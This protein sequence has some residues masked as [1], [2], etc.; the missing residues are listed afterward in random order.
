MA[1]DYAAAHPKPSW[2]ANANKDNFVDL[3]LYHIKHH[4]EALAP[5]AAR[6]ATPPAQ[7]EHGA[8]LL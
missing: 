5:P 6:V 7:S 3:L 2:L 4:D 8:P 1:F